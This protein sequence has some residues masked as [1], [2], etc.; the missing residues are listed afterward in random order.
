MR[1]LALGFQPPKTARIIHP[2][3]AKDFGALN[4]SI[5]A[6]NAKI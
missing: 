5:G 1:E 6:R 2:Y 4:W 3:M